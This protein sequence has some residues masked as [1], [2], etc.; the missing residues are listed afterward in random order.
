MQH[1]CGGIGRS[2]SR[3]RVLRNPRRLAGDGTGRARGP[4]ASAP[5]RKRTDCHPPRRVHRPRRQTRCPV[6]GPT[7][8]RLAEKARHESLSDHEDGNATGCGVSSRSF[9]IGTPSGGGTGR[10]TGH[11]LLELGSSE[12]G[13]PEQCGL[14]TRIGLP[15][16]RVSTRRGHRPLTRIPRRVLRHPPPCA[17]CAAD[18]EN[19]R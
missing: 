11:Q 9:G 16:R 19:A 14:A 18:V 3:L 12:S 8:R 1:H 4:G 2:P 17:S 15:V 6:L 7:L 13:T 5:G 10:V